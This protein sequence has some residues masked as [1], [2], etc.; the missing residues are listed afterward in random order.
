MKSE[1]TEEMRKRHFVQLLLFGRQSE[2]WKPKIKYS[3]QWLIKV[4]THM[5]E[6]IR[7]DQVPIF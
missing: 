2:K 3:V 4:K 6:L 7:T 5:K 1:N